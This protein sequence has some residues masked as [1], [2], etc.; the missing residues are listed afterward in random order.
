M[1][2]KQ[3]VRKKHLISITL[4]MVIVLSGIALFFNF[5]TTNG[6]TKEI[7]PLIRPVKTMVLSKTGITETRSFPGI[8]RAAAE[9]ELAFRVGGPLVEFNVHR[10]QYVEKG[11]VIAR[12][13]P[14]DFEVRVMQLE[15][16]LTRERANLKAMR[17]GARVEDIAALE[18]R[19]TAAE[20]QMN[21]SEKTLKRYGNL[22]GTKAVSQA[23]F[24][25]A[26]SGYD[27]ARTNVN[28]ILQEL[29]KARMGA[30]SEEIEAA[31]AG[32]KSLSADLKAAKNAVI[33]TRLAAPFEGYIDQKYVD[34][35]ENVKDGDPIV[36][37]LD[38]SSVEISTAIPEDLVI[39][40]SE[41]S[42]IS[43]ALDAYPGLSIEAT[44]NEIG[45]KTE[46][47][48]Q[49]YPMTVILGIPENFNVEPGMA[50][51]VYIDLKEGEQARDFVLPTIAVF[52]DS[53]G[54]SCVWRIDTQTMRV[55][56]TNVTTGNLIGES[57]QVLSGL[58]PGD[59]I[60]TA[61]ARFLRDNQQ[62]RLLDKGLE[63]DR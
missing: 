26:E 12:I 15:A 44:I 29:K 60:V 22:L 13:D 6:N 50:A 34:N 5:D 62:V 1:Q 14:R 30:R 63:E 59:K 20:S 56:R 8:V 40:R 46:S 36:S 23:L 32:I 54:Q 58:N 27:V 55:V 3:V 16:A 28:A 45:R 39:R 11:E 25:Q 21:Q 47:A 37:I 9:T 24:D 61:G 42:N 53:K 49:S 33:D 48:N 17:A 4:F 41:I 31:E 43:C 52:A 7:E 57:I 38:F 51:N 2:K 18:A 10:G 19:L 35:Y